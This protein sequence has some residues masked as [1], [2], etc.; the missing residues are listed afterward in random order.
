M[1]SISELVQ[2]A[3]L[4]DA[5]NFII[6]AADTENG[7]SAIDFSHLWSE[8]LAFKFIAIPT[9]DGAASGVTRNLAL[10]NKSSRN[11]HEYKSLQR[12]SSDLAVNIMSQSF[13]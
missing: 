5:Q 13:P 7:M 6:V 1:S 11:Y 9:N 8:Q 4:S 2:Y 12:N 3:L 10:D